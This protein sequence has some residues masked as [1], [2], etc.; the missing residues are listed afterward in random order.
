MSSRE[1][2]LIDIILFNLTRITM[3]IILNLLLFALIILLLMRLANKHMKF[4]RRVFIATGIGIVA[5]VLLQLLYPEE[6]IQKTLDWIGI[7]GDGY[8]R[9]LQVIVI[10]LIFISIL[11]AILHLRHGGEGVGKMALMI[12]GILVGTA[13]IA[14]LVGVFTA[15]SF[16]L[17]VEGLQM[18]AQE[19]A[20]GVVLQEKL[21]S[22]ENM[23]FS[24]KIVNLIP[25]NI[26][27]DFSGS[28][29]S[30]T[31]GVVIFT[32][33]L[34]IAALGIHKKKPAQFEFFE[35]LTDSLHD[36]IMRMV[37]LVLRLT[38]YG[39]LALM[40]RM[41][42][43]SSP[44][45]ILNLGTFIL[46]S[47][48]ALIAMFLIHLLLIALVRLNPLHYLKKVMPVL[49]FAFTSRSSM[50]TI[51]LN[52]ETQIDKMGVSEGVANLSASLGATI[53]Q[54]GCAAIYPA[55]LAV[56]IA[57]VMH[58]DP[59]S[60]EFIVKLVAIIAISSFGV[61]GVGGGATF[62]ALI[63]LSSM[64]F[65]VALVGLL[66]S[67]EPL[68]DMGRTA[69]NVSGAMT[70]GVITSRLMKNLNV[71]KYQGRDQLDL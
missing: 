44:Q 37:T 11:S 42:A 33:F 63:V 68:I 26:F 56:M 65:P 55:M 69:L 25:T 49:T 58:I 64:N 10:P 32:A 9:L 67:V 29:D 3:Y 53:G 50:G 39:I 35:K 34:G 2:A 16:G 1:F 14:A 45:D 27:Q 36:V 15:N 13:V 47:Y 4:S 59:T 12:V 41:V 23:T 8:I 60:W 46:A 28:R 19:N 66:I 22:V 7:V 17:S 5:G 51:P 61:A 38:P 70:T 52:V 20:R 21:Q 43:T 40:T 48:T 57:P 71:A 6:V 54:N 62:A 24:R 18:G 30:S 31:I